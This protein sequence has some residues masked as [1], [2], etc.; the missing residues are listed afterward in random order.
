MYSGIDGSE[1]PTLQVIHKPER[2]L[3]KLLP[4]IRILLQDLQIIANALLKAGTP[5]R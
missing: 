4:D 5:K 2:V 1:Q 3:G